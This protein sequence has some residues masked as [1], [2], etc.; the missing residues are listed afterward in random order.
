MANEQEEEQLFV[1]SCFTSSISSDCWLIDSGCTNHMTGDEE[2]FRE[3]DRSQVSKVR[4]GNGAYI[5][6]KG[7]GT[8]AI[9]SCRGT[10]LISDV[11]FV[12]EID[13]NLLSVRQL[14]SKG[15]KVIFENEQC[16]IKDANNVDVFRI[17][18][19]GKSY[20]FDPMEEEQAVYSANTTTAE[21]W[22]KRMGHFHHAALLNMQRKDLAIGFPHIETELPN[23]RS[24]QYGKQARTPFQ[25]ATWRA[26]SKLQLIH[27]DLC[28]PQRTPS[29]NGSRHY[30]IFIDDF[31]RMCWICFLRFKSE[32]ASVF[33]KFK[34]WIENQSGCKIQVLRS[35][36]GKEY[37][38]SEFNKF[39]EDSGIE[40]HITASYSPQQNGV[41][42]RETRTI[43]EMSRCM[44]HEKNLP[45][46]YS[47]VAT[48]T[49]VFLLNR[50]PTKAVNGKTP[51][52]AWY[53]YKPLIKNLK[54][55]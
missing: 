43:M 16:L 18:M 5:A 54:V 37:T 53:S 17:K 52:E 35:D 19:K 31:T 22:H 45:K 20:P 23:C 9:E 55:F 3:L 12:P 39:C 32:V 4:I 34:Q 7:K 36:N 6:V 50:L 27:T 24:C 8:I 47:A 46:E 40:H 25:Q 33:F 41:S 38:S 30:I 48:N 2:L 11:L 14:T 21:L 10:K 26:T 44:L 28:G 1:A 51:Y 13:Q 49:S 15:F 29:L 42:E